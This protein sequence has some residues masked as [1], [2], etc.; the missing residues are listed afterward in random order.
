[1]IDRR[2]FL[3]GMVGAIAAPAVIKSGILMPVKEII[4]PDGIALTTI[5]HPLLTKEIMRV[6]REA[7]IPKLQMQIYTPSPSWVAIL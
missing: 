4:M 2:S 3:R 1:M 6:T 5:P 7:F